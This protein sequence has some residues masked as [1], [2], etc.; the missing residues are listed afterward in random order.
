VDR[1]LVTL[2]LEYFIKNLSTG[3][4]KKSKKFKRYSSKLEA[5]KNKTTKEKTEIMHGLP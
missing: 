2:H 5:M 1:W 4:G 3:T